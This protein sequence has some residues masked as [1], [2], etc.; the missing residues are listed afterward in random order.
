MKII[1]GISIENFKRYKS[2]KLININHKELEQNIKNIVLTSSQ[3]RRFINFNGAGISKE[4]FEQQE[5]SALEVLKEKIIQAI[6]EEETRIQL[7][8]VDIS[9]VDNS[10]IS[11]V[12]HYS[13]ENSLY[14]TIRYK[15]ISEITDNI[16]SYTVEI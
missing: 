15:L 14:I 3:E 7:V 16:N 2:D 6:K 1:K 10:T 9:Y 8:S 12:K 11:E 13:D 4:L 5:D